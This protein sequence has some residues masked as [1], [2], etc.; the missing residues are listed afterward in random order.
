M[1]RRQFLSSLLA[2]GG[3]AG[4]GLITAPAFASPFTA[5]HPR[6]LISVLLSGGPDMRHLMPPAYSSQTGTIGYEYWQATASSHGVE[7]AS[8]MQARFN[9]AYDVIG[10]DGDTE[11]GL[12]KSCG[13]LKSMW[14]QGNVAI[15]NNVLGSSS[16]NH[17]LSVLASELGNRAVTSTTTLSPGVG[18]RLAAASGG[19]MVSLTPAP[20]GYCY[21]PSTDNMNLRSTQGLI[22]ARNTREL[23]LFSGDPAEGDTSFRNAITRNVSAYY[24]AKA[25]NSLASDR[26]GKFLAHNN[27]LKL[28]GEPIDERLSGLPVPASLARLYNPELMPLNSTR[29]GLQ[30]RN[31]YDSLACADIL[32][33]SV[34]SLEYK[35]F[36][37]H[38]SQI[39][40]LEPRFYDLFGSDQA[41]DS[42]YAELPSSISDQLVLVLNGEFGR[43][44]RSNGD[45]GTDH[46]EGGT[47]LIIGA[48]VNGGLYGE[49]FPEQELALLQQPSPQIKGLTAVERIH[50][51]LAEWHTPGAGTQL[52]P[53]ASQSPLES[54]VNLNA[55][56]PASV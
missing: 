18:G 41:L 30:V 1:D 24:Q 19:N 11:F 16:R 4:S 49:M 23:T 27:T 37:S 45:G 3:L 36:D 7:S 5:N 46:G 44:I 50:A 51:L 15:V 31:L 42:L 17:P 47:T 52:F 26:H 12:L 35:G 9:D 38:R 8:E 28:L 25:A 34:A 33:L 40:T 2:T 54:G 43:Q 21:G 13:W 53:D 39:E 29:F 48:A 6:L 10:A 14:E 20:R 55:I 56:L 32:N 22:S